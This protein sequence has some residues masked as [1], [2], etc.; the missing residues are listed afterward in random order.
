MRG[1]LRRI[2]FL[3]VLVAAWAAVS[4]LGWVK[5]WV[6]PSPLEVLRSGWDG[7]TDGLSHA[8]VGSHCATLG[9]LVYAVL[10]SLRRLAIG[11]LAS[12]VGGVL[13]GLGLA[14][15]QLV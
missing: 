3:L 14:R 11:Y 9:S 6:L 10:V 15:S 1:R 13:L 2:G 4:S 8:C 7:L 12:V 5:P